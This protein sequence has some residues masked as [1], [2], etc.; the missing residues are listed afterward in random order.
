MLGEQGFVCIRLIDPDITNA[1]GTS[2]R[3]EVSYLIN[4]P[5]FAVFDNLSIGPIGAPLPVNFI[6]LV[7]NRN[8]DNMVALKWDVSEEVDVA[9][10][11]VE[12]STNGST[13]NTA[14]SVNAKG[15]SIYSFTD[16]VVTTN[17]VFYR[18]K[19][20]DINGSVKYSGVV[21]LKGNSPNSFS[22]NLMVY[23]TP[24]TDQ[25]TVEHARIT[26]DAKLMITSIDGKVVK[27]IVPIEGSSHTPVDISML[28]PGMYFLRL[29]EGGGYIQTA[30]LIK[31]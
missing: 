11:D 22:D 28:K 5:F 10:Y 16:P 9:R 2:Y 29:D 8:S 30:K 23:P 25:I 6:G 12:R 21:R 14:G 24:A 7:A 20:V 17:T 27:V 3:V 18:V 26:R 1:P 19:S 31:K 13:F 4:D 15:K